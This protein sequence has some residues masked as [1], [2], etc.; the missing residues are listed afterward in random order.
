MATQQISNRRAQLATLAKSRAALHEK[1]LRMAALDAADEKRER[2][3]DSKRRQTEA[4]RTLGDAIGGG[5]AGGEEVVV[6]GDDG[7]PIVKS[8]AEASL[9]TLYYIS[10]IA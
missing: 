4:L 8:L 10:H 9:I 6:S 5:R 7:A 1:G 3:T 2:E